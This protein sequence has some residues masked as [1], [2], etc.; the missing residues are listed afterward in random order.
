MEVMTSARLSS[1]AASDMA[2][3]ALGRSIKRRTD[4]L[5]TFVNATSM[6]D[7]TT[8]ATMNKAPMSNSVPLSI[9]TFAAKG[10]DIGWFVEVPVLAIVAAHHLVRDQDH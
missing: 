6:M 7:I 8:R 2:A 3:F 9:G 4:T 5:F 10:Q 1:I